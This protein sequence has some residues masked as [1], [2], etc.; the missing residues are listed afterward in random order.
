MYIHVCGAGNF[1]FEPVIR[2]L[3]QLFEGQLNANGLYIGKCYSIVEIHVH[4]SA[5]KSLGISMVY[6]SKAKLS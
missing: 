3:W 6:A 2:K 4:V 1:E 5:R